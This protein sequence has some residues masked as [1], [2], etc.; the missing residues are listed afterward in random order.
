MTHSTQEI[1][2]LS[3]NLGY[4]FVPVSNIISCISEGNYTHVHLHGGKKYTTSKS[5]KLVCDRLDPD[6]FVR[7]HHSYLVNLDHI[8]KFIAEPEPV[9]V[10]IDGSKLP[11]SRR[12]KK[13]LFDR[14]VM[15]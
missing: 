12:R 7:I 1:L 3:D 2:A 15:L 4:H 5:L 6:L 8:Q 14:F 10:M 9:V 13:D 11:V